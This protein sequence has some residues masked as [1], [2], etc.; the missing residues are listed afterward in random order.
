MKRKKEHKQQ[1]V[2]K[3]N[4]STTAKD[5]NSERWKYYSALTIILILSFIIYLPVLQN[6]FVWDDDFYIKNNPLIYSINLNEFFT[7]YV[8]GNYHPVTMLTLAIEY[9]FFGLNATGYHAVNL[10]LHLLNVLLVF[11]TVFLLS[12]KIGVALVASLL[13]GI[14]PMH[15]ES[16]A[17]AVELKDLLYTFFF[18]LS[19]FFYLKYLIDPQKKNYTLS[20]LLFLVSL[21]S[22]AMAASLPIV[23]ILTD[24]FKGR[25]INGKIFLEKIPF[26]LLSITFGIVAIL[27]QQSSGATDIIDFAFPQRILFACYGFISYLVKLIFPL[28]LSAFYPYPVNGGENIPIYL[29][30]Y[31][32]LFISLVVSVI[33]SLRFT[34]KIFFCLAFFTATVFLVLQLLPVGKTIMADRYS[35][36]SSIGIFYLAGEGFHLL[37]S[38]KLKSTAI[39]LLSIFIVF[40]SVKTYARCGVWEN[41]LTL[42]TD[43]I[44]HYKSIE[45][46]YY[47]RGNYL[48][49]KNKYDEAIR[50]FN[51]AIEVKPDYAEAYNNRGNL[52]S[53]A[54]SNDAAMNDFNQAI[55]LSPAYVD[56]YI[57][58][59]NLF[60]KENRNDEAIR[61]FNK[62]IELKPDDAQAYNNRGYLYQTEKR[63]DLAIDDYNKAITLRPDFAEAYY[64][65]GNLL[66]EEKAYEEAISVFTKA[67][68][69]KADYAKAY[70]NRGVVEYYSGRNDAACKDLKKAAGLGFQ[71][72]GN[73][74]LQICK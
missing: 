25:K 70:Y 40:F 54:N 58:R 33:Y 65:K 62:A 13:F 23:L 30:V 52:F 48:I 74:L 43:V 37:W 50:D 1:K 39:I 15:V 5:T 61:D 22:K 71:P 53:N 9:Q 41:D 4:P 6:S 18:L 26:F 64:N 3:K 51:K 20:L 45:E 24:Y 47:N 32:I 72:A 2:G 46:A 56:A 38:K 60:M 31:L 27:A 49:E 19:Y 73:L 8:M 21:L 68:A 42:W 16:I 17:W 12:N 7:Q 63:N 59:G 57:N 11:Y 55:E 28:Q 69:L 67:I 34:K 14:H 10:L 44:S 29:Y 66:F 35:Y 36:I